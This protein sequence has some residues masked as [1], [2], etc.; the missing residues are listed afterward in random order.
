MREERSDTLLAVLISPPARK[1][2]GVGLN[3]FELDFVEAYQA[4]RSLAGT[5]VVDEGFVF[6]FRLIERTLFGQRV[7]SAVEVFQHEAIV[8]LAQLLQDDAIV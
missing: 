1:G 4:P 5:F 2:L 3:S 8:V 7:C 6:V